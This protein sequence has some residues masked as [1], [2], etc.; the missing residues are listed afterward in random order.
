MIMGN[1]PKAIDFVMGSGGL[2]PALAAAAFA[3]PS[4]GQDRMKRQLDLVLEINIG[5]WPESQQ[6]G[7]L[8]RH[9]IEQIGLDKGSDG[10]REWRASPGQAHR[11]PEGFPT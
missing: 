1:L 9:F 10:W 8:G 6:L 5:L 3:T 2:D 11:H 4:P 7:N